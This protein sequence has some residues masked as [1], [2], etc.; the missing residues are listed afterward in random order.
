MGQTR[1]E[2]GAIQSRERE[3]AGVRAELPF[4]TRSLTVAALYDLAA[5][6]AHPE[7]LNRSSRMVSLNDFGWANPGVGSPVKP[8]VPA[9]QESSVAESPL[10]GEMTGD[11]R[12]AP[13]Q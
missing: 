9:A 3:R 7:C 12:S 11:C 5:G 10:N 2:T 13:K 8:F 1:P 4:A 6:S